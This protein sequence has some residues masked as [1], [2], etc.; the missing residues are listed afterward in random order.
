MK[1][2]LIKTEFIKLGQLLKFIGVIQNGSNA[3]D[4]LLSNLVILNETQENKRGKK[5]YPNSKIIINNIE[6]FVKKG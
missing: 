2:I 5:I 3:K 6:Y 1:E 4:F